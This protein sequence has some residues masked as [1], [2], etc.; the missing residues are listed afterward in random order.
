[1]TAYTLFHS[2]SPGNLT[3]IKPSTLPILAPLLP[4]AAAAL[5][6]EVPLPKERAERIGLNCCSSL[7]PNLVAV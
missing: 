1:M 4:A 3:S 2:V 7:I 5:Y 6:E